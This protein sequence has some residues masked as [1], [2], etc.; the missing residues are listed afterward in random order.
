MNPQENKD[1]YWTDQQP[2]AEAPSDYP[3][4]TYQPSPEDDI[5]TV[6]SEEAP[7]VDVPDDI[8]VQ[9]VAHEY[10]H[11]D[12]GFLWYIVFILA[13]LALI[14]ADVFLLKSWTFSVLVVVMA[15]ALIVYT[16]R[17][18]RDIQYALSGR[19]GL[20]VGE[21]LYH[22]SDFKA[23]GLIKDGDHHSIMLIP[24]KRF[25]PGVSVYFPEEAG[26]KIVDILGQR[27]PMEELKLDMIDVIVRQL[28]L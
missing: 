7:G 16:R 25:S 15:I 17:P 1:N 9:W 21:K 28:R 5:Q 2:E 24:V 23:F 22:L 26:E 12:K 8:P 4:D 13:V 19:Q 18:P 10:I 20:Y 6:G 14:A 27:L 11:V 3:Q